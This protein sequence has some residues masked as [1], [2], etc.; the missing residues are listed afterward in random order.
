MHGQGLTQAS[1][2]RRSPIAVLPL[3]R[4]SDPE[5]VS[6]LPVARPPAPCPLAPGLPPACCSICMYTISQLQSTLHTRAGA[7]AGKRPALVHLPGFFLHCTFDL[8]C[9]SAP[10]LTAARPPGPARLRSNCHLHTLAHTYADIDYFVLLILHGMEGQGPTQASS[11]RLSP[12]QLLFQR[13][14]DLGHIS[15]LVIRANLP[16]ACL[17]ACLPIPLPSFS[18]NLDVGCR[19]AFFRVVICHPIDDCCS[20][21]YHAANPA[22][23]AVPA[24]HCRISLEA[25][26]SSLSHAKEP[27]VGTALV[28]RDYRT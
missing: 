16:A 25:A 27:A 26:P 8:E 1:G 19:P 9:G 14:R 4:I 23:P 15:M 20:P 17:P 13:F 2:L 5:C 12:A 21:T 18:R 10:D 3:H 11:L 6:A 24:S 7:H 28:Q 22:D